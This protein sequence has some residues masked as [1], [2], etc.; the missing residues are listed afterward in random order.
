MARYHRQTLLPQIGPDGQRALGASHVVVVGCGALGCAVI[1]TLARAGVG[2]LT[3]IDR[4]VVELSN[5]H[6]QCL[7]DESD[8]E[9][10]SPK[11]AA[12]AARVRVISAHTGVRAVV[13]DLTHRNA[14]RVVLGDARPMVVVDGTDNFATRYLLN[15]L[16]VKHRLPLVYGGVVATRGTAATI[17]PGIGPCLR[18]IAPTIPA[19]G[20]TPTC[21]TAGVFGPAVQTVGALQASMVIRLLVNAEIT[22]TLAEFDI[23]DLAFRTVPIQGLKDPECPC[24]EA[25]TYEL[26]ESPDDVEA[27]ALCGQHTIQVPPTGSGGVDLVTLAA[28]L[29][30]VAS[31]QLTPHMLRASLRDEHAGM[32]LTVFPTGRA[33]VRGTD[34]PEVARSLYARFVGG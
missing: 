30:R 20:S 27:A 17:L 8:A 28:R 26:L 1:D 22:P 29:E 32:V 19:P 11:A 12:V 10:G 33:L 2:F 9:A 34:R 4:D 23:W 25:G 14:E 13:D 18:C 16:A 21:D 5:L 24:C 15:D 7:F 3:V 31:V 6:R